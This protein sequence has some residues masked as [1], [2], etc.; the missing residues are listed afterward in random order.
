M[1]WTTA[2]T[3]CVRAGGLLCTEKYGICE[4]KDQRIWTY[5][6]HERMHVLVGRN[7][8]KNTLETKA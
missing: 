5:S 2:V 1:M 8:G 3:G 4:A 6:M 7:E